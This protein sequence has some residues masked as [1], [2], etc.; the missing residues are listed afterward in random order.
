MHGHLRFVCLPV[1][2]WWHHKRDGRRHDENYTT[3]AICAIFGQ[4]VFWCV[5]VSMGRVL[6]NSRLGRGR[7]W[8]QIKTAISDFSS[9]QKETADRRVLLKKR[10]AN[11]CCLVFYNVTRLWSRDEK[12]QD[13][14]R[15]TWRERKTAERP[16]LRIWYSQKI[17]CRRI[18]D[19]FS[20]LF[21]WYHSMSLPLFACV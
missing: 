20:D 8:V 4:P 6:S 11:S 15:R 9:N 21:F 10:T 2:R 12:V 5:Q 3:T 13:G 18:P 14:G 19:I 16:E 7:N 17:T 1:Y